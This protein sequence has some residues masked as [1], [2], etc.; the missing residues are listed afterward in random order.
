MTTETCYKLTTQGLTTHCG[1]QWTLGE[2]RETSGEGEL[3]G[4]G[5]LHAYSDPYLAVFMNPH[6]ANIKSPRFFRAEGRG[7]K[8]D[9]RGMKCG[10]TQMRIVE[11]LPAIE[12]TLDQRVEFGIRCALAVCSDEKFVKW[13]NKWLSGE[14]RTESSASAAYAAASASYYAADYAAAA[15][16]AA[17]ASAAYATRSAAYYAADYAAYYAADYAAAASAAD[18][19][20]IAHQVMGVQ[21]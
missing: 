6:H 2:W 9:D 10:F 8:L 7:K 15:A 21:Q 4:P 14:D 1:Y 11:E 3:C 20:A 13:A 16:S 18:L 12:P 17:Y 19:I 5:F